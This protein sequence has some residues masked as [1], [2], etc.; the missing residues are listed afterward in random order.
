M[1]NKT[2]KILLTYDKKIF[3]PNGR[4]KKMSTNKMLTWYLDAY[5][6]VKESW[7]N[8]REEV[9][10]INAKKDNYNMV[11]RLAKKIFKI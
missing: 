4:R 1:K 2:R 10:K 9:S 3:S 7:W 5:V 6:S 8:L 11:Q